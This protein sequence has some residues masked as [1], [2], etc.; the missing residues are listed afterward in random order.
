MTTPSGEDDVEQDV[1]DA[2]ADRRKFSVVKMKLASFCSEPALRAMIDA[3]ASPRTTSWAKPTPR[4]FS[5]DK[6]FT[7]G[8]A[9]EP[10]TQKFYYACLACVSKMNVRESTVSEAKS[11]Y[12]FRCTAS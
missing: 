11:S 3:A 6:N 8:A 2:T 12:S 9:Q 1:A 5:C 4:E 10:I 7:A